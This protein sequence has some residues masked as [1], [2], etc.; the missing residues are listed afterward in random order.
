MANE[1]YIYDEAINSIGVCDSFISMIWIKRYSSAGTF[2]LH[3]PATEYNT[4][5]LVPNRYIYRADVDEAMYIAS[6]K[7]TCSSEDGKTITVSGYSLDGMFRKRRLPSTINSNSF[8]KTLIDVLKTCLSFGCEIVFSDP[9]NLDTILK[10]DADKNYY[11]D[12]NAEDYIRWALDKSNFVKETDLDYNF[13]NPTIYGLNV[14]MNTYKH[15]LECSIY[16]GK[17]LTDSIVFSED[18][19]NMFNSEYSF[20]EIGGGNVIY[21][22]CNDFDSDVET[23]NG[24]PSCVINKDIIGLK[25]TEKVVAIDPVIKVGVRLKMVSVD[26]P[27]MVEEYNYLDYDETMTNLMKTC[28][29]KA[30]SFDENFTGDIVN[31]DDYRVKF[32]VGDIVKIQNGIRGISYSKRIEEIEESFDESGTKVTPTFGKPLKTIYDYIKI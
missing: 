25:A 28:N 20:S 19:D 17:D 27:L 30:N 24:V 9:N 32:D 10:I 5:M 13:N 7:E 16:N 29:S 8:K 23:P 18:Y 22:I 4:K 2:E 14:H 26:A 12:M 15:C 11:V 31:V 1:V 6:I 21:G 3:V